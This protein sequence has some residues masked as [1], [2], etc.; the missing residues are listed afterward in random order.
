MEQQR[1]AHIHTEYLEA[2]RQ[3]IAEWVSREMDRSALVTITKCTESDRGG[4]VT[5]FVSTLPVDRTNGA[6]SFLTRH[7]A[8]IANAIG[9]KFRNHRKPFLKFEIDVADVNKNPEE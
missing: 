7:A 6:M 3:T 1:N 4:R 8:D 2:I 5:V 9:K